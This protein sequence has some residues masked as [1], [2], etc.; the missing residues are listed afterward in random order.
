MQLAMT[1]V[2]E[3]SG[4]HRRARVSLRKSVFP[5]FMK[6]YRMIIP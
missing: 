1:I 6:I 4:N 3:E 2:V 5:A